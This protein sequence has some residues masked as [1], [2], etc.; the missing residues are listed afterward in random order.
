MNRK[1]IIA[2]LLISVFLLGGCNGIVPDT[3][4]N[5]AIVGV[6]KVQL[7]NQNPVFSEGQP[8]IEFTLEGVVSG[9][10]G[11]NTY[12]AL[13]K[14]QGEELTFQEYTQLGNECVNEDVLSQ[15]SVFREALER[16]ATFAENSGQLILYDSTG[17]EIITLVEE[18]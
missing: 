1:L 13:Y 14:R 11:C 8:T 5:E 18:G 16:V 7:L 4:Q 3:N 2:T 9:S 12:S 17:T 6:W 15:E 10:T